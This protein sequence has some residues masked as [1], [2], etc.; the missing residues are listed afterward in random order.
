MPGYVIHIAI[1]QE[2]LRKKNKPYSIEFIRGSIAP[3]FTT[4]KSVTH[5]GKSPAYTSLQA[6]LKE[7]KMIA[8]YDRGYF[9]HLVSDYL[10]YNKYLSKCSKPE[11]YNDYDITNEELIKR[12]NVKILE[13]VKDKIF[14]KE[15]ET[16]IFD[17]QLA[18]KVIDEISD[19]SIERIIEEVNNGNLK[20]STY[21]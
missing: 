16:K 6:F 3:D 17:V 2:Y 14:F 4:Q 9:L 19:L 10:F 15:G 12:Y 13:E 7:N 20:W 11:I 5:Y 21:K 1:A 8:D 18:C